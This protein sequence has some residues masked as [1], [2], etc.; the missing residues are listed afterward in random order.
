MNT[1]I[2]D[3]VNLAWKLAAVLHGRADPS[4]LDSYEPERIAFAR[5]LVATTDQAFTGVTSSG[6][7]AR[8]LRLHVVPALIPTLF[9]LK[10]MRRFM[11]RTV[12]Q[13][14]GELPWQQLERGPRR[15]GSRRRSSAV[16]E[17]GRQHVNAD[18]FAPLTSL[19]W[20]VHVYGDATPEIQAVCEARKLPLHVFPW[21]AEMAQ[22]GLR[23][24]AVYLVRPDGYVALADAEGSAAAIA[25]YLD[26]R[27]LTS[28]KTP[29][30]ATRTVRGRE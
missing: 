27:N 23:R 28:V 21:R 19:D 12:S 6:P 9:A 24:N 13:T 22:A 26:A 2:G 25:S 16:G 10:A 4:L 30:P 17:N 3:A 1:G 15:D 29:A 20:Q 8:L 18:N 7:I 11:F 5:R 14:G